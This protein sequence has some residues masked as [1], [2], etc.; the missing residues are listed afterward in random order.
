M[1]RQSEQKAS[2]VER[3][4]QEHADLGLGSQEAEDQMTSKE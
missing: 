4:R 1:S 3:R 2:V